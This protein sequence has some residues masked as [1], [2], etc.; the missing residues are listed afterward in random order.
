MSSD[1]R[2]MQ[3]PLLSSR[4]TALLPQLMYDY[5]LHQRY[6]RTASVLGRDL[7]C[8]GG[9]LGEAELS[10]IAVRQQSYDLVAAG[11]IE[12]ALALVRDKFPPE[13]SARRA[14]LVGLPFVCCAVRRCAGGVGWHRFARG[15]RALRACPVVAVQVCNLCAVLAVSG[16]AGDAS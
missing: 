16:Q 6:W 7:L 1:V 13:V 9:R 10:D 2:S 4:G 14:L 5:L 15:E 3:L 8:A 11:R 12:E